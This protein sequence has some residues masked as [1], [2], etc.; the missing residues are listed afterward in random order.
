MAMFICILFY[1]GGKIMIHLNVDLIFKI[2]VC[3]A[4]VRSLIF[5]VD[6]NQI[7]EINKNIALKKSDFF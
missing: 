4:D 1:D 2:A 5:I 6:F 7:V 3:D